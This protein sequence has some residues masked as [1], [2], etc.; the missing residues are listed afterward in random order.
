MRKTLDV[1]TLEA[2]REALR[3]EAAPEAAWIDRLLS[4]PVSSGKENER[5]VSLPA[6][7]ALRVFS[8]LIG[9]EWRRG[10]QAEFGGMPVHDLL[11]AWKR[12]IL[13]C[14]DSLPGSEG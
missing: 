6:V 9:V 12:A 2:V 8:I 7:E 11:E 1:R 3:G 14:L 4:A 5:E 13:P 10:K